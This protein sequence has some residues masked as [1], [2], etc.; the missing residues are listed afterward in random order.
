MNWF[1]T[2]QRIFKITEL[3]N[4]ILF[5]VGILIL[6]R[7]AAHIPIPGVNRE[8]LELFFSQNEIFG[9][10]NIF[11]GGG[12]EA[13][14]VV[15][16]GV[17][18][19]ITSSIIFQLLTMVIPRLEA[20][21]KEG[22]AGRARINQYTRILV[23]PLAMLQGF[24]LV[25]LL[26]SSNAG[27]I[28]PNL[29]LLSFATILITLTAGTVFLMWL[30]ELISERRIGNG[31]SILIFAGIVAGIPGAVGN[32][33]VNF[34]V[35]QAQNIVLFLAIA[36]VTIVGIVL[37]TEAQRNVPV[38]YAR[39]IRG[40]RMYGGTS[41]HLPLRVNQAG[42]IPI[43]FAISLVLFPPLIAQ[44][45]TRVNN[46]FITRASQFVIRIFQ[47]DHLVYTVIYFLLV[48][49]FTY[50][51]TFVIFHPQQIAE[52]LQKQGGFIP[53]IR[54]GKTTA[55]FLNYIVSRIVLAGALFLGFLALL[56][57]VMQK[58]TGLSIAI[59]GA[60]LLIVVGV[61]IDIVKQIESQL[62]MREYEG[63]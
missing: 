22:E 5:V 10:I 58:T 2:L 47:P 29:P 13:F 21:A 53:G 34:D 39:R 27:V 42:M 37:I 23:V 60:S 43:I 9:L 15:A 24:G 38:S 12:L 16:L 20:L 35:S 50:F 59:S 31:I 54:P 1:S 33:F 19:Y 51:Y 41:A 36:F 17:A 30:G 49:G 32:V 4:S 40:M 6:F 14:S 63:F 55:D 3:R 62:T 56:P 44:F 18:P 8:N 26:Q 61:V 48:V 57:F 46:D 45:L 11:S 28:S 25:R 7:L 52:N